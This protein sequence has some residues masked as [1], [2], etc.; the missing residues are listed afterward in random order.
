MKLV[1]NKEIHN[2]QAFTK[3][4]IELFADAKRYKRRHGK[5]V[6]FC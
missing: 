5:Q 3:T 4:H 6:I 2:I 1:T